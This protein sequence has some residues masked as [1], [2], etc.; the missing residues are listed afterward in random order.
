VVVKRAELGDGRRSS[1]F[2]VPGFVFGDEGGRSRAAVL[3][4]VVG[5]AAMGAFAAGSMS[6]KSKMD[7]DEEAA[8]KAPL[9][10]RDHASIDIPATV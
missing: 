7:R 4:L 9:L 2:S 6:R 1:S 8:E 10:A 3:A 5:I